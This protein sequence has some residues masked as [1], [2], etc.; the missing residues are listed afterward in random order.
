MLTVLLA[1]RSVAPI[2]SMIINV[3]AAAPICY[4][5]LDDSC[6]YIQPLG[7]VRCSFRDWCLPN[8]GAIYLKVL[9][10]LLC[11]LSGFPTSL[12]IIMELYDLSLTEVNVSRIPFMH[13]FH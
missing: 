9:N 11:S 8:G 7:T 3:Y 13:Q 10:N 12:R 5:A 6:T 4:T 2:E 1:T